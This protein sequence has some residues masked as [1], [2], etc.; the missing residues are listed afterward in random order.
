M[1]L[2]VGAPKAS[3]SDGTNWVY[4]DNPQSFAL[5]SQ[6]AVNASYGGGFTVI[7]Y[8]LFIITLDLFLTILTQNIK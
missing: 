3:S 8:S 2:T 6:Y 1:D 7:I 4:Y 5:K